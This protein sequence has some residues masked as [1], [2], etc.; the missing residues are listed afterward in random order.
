MNMARLNHPKLEI[1][2]PIRFSEQ[3]LRKMKT[4]LKAEIMNIRNDN[5]HQFPSVY[6]I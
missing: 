4:I 3:V 1:Q 6:T 5:K 2:N